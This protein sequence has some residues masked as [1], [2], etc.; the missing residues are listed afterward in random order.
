M[1]LSLLPPN[2][3]REMTAQAHQV[4]HR[5]EHKR[6]GFFAFVRRLLRN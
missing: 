2:T 1:Y 3:F 5:S 6:E 4:A